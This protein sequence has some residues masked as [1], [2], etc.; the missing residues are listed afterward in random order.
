L[1]QKPLTKTWLSKGEVLG[2][3]LAFT[4]FGQG[5]GIQKCF[6]ECCLQLRCPDCPLSL[7]FCFSKH[8]CLLLLKSPTNLEN[9]FC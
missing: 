6:L 9:I 7:W 2:A 3:G 5:L 1:P 4:V 8:R